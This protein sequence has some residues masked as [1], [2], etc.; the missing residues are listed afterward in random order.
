MMLNISARLKIPDNEIEMSA[1][2]SQGAGGQN[3]NKVSTAVHLRFDIKASSLPRWIKDRLLAMHDSRI[4]KEGIIVIKSQEYRSLEKNRSAALDRLAGI[5]KSAA[6]TPKKRKPT[7]PGKQVRRK[8]MDAKTRRGKIKRLR[9]RH[10]I[11]L[12]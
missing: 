12:D 5:I 7:K 9:D 2:R 1:V 8:H 3:V 10:L 6:T 4:N 11:D